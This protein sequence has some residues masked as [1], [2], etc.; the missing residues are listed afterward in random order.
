MNLS[1]LKASR[2]LWLRRER[3][4]R[5]KW[6]FYR[7]S[8]KRNAADRLR[9]RRKWW[10]LYVAARSQRLARERQI[11][12]ATPKPSVRQQAVKYALS[13]EGQTERPAGSN[14]GPGVISRCQIDI[15]GADGYAWCGCFDGF[16]LRWA[17]VKG[18]TS[19]IASVEFI[20]QDAKNKQGP[21]SGWSQNA[22]G[23]LPGDLVVL[24]GRG[25]HVGIIVKVYPDGSVDTI[26]GN[27]SSDDGGSQANGGGV[28]PR[29][30]L[31]SAIHGVAHVDY[32]G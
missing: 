22:R 5:A 13:F 12:A 3:Y 20:E 21:F 8:S 27:T 11:S 32:P 25:V 31:S 4:R 2:L 17:G 1:Q 6:H 26:E 15:L 23:A 24:F 28:F 18:V 19:R 16:I 10:S 9:L 30:R 7:Y 14:T 29:H